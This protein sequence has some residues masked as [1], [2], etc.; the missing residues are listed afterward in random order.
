M[1]RLSDLNLNRAVGILNSITNPVVAS[2]F[3]RLFNYDIDTSAVDTSKL[4]Y[5]AY[6][7]WEFEYHSLIMS[8][9][10]M[11]RSMENNILTDDMSLVRIDGQRLLWVSLKGTVNADRLA[12]R[13]HWDTL[14]KPRKPQKTVPS[15]RR[16]KL[17]SQLLRTAP[18][19]SVLPFSFSP[20][21]WASP[22]ASI[23][24]IAFMH[25]K[26]CAFLPPAVPKLKDSVSCV[27]HCCLK[28]RDLRLLGRSR[29]VI[30]FVNPRFCKWT[31]FVRYR[32]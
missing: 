25:S 27:R 32:C 18:H 29:F 5:L 4:P 13:T 11:S 1:R 30:R 22:W 12:R 8:N 7:N 2:R 20:S 28:S 31:N 6:F 3:A 9:T 16:F 26:L 21:S 24:T 14:W 10:I 23:Q 17:L 19:P 15:E